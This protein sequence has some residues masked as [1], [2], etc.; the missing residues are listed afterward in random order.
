MISIVENSSS[1][2]VNENLE[3]KKEE[4]SEREREEREAAIF[5]VGR[6]G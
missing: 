4:Q 3:L 1:R 5:K 6:E 2:K